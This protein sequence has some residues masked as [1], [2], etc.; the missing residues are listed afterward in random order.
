MEKIMQFVD[1]LKMSI[2][3]NISQ[4]ENMQ[5]LENVYHL[6]L[7]FEKFQMKRKHENKQ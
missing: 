4:L 7:K 2:K 3:Q 1:R 6:A 5:L